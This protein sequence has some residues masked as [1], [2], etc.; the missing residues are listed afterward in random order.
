MTTTLFPRRVIH[1]SKNGEVSIWNVDAAKIEATKKIFNQD[2]RFT[3]I[4][5][6]R[7]KVYFHVFDTFREDKLSNYILTI[8]IYSVD[9]FS[10]VPF[11]NNN[12]LLFYRNGDFI[13][14]NNT[15]ALDLSSNTFIKDLDLTNLMEMSPHRFN[16]SKQSD[17]DDQDQEDE[18]L[19]RASNEI[20]KSILKI[21]ENLYL[22]IKHIVVNHQAKSTLDLLHIVN[23]D[24]RKKVS[25][26]KID[27]YPFTEFGLHIDP[28]IKISPNEFLLV[29]KLLGRSFL[30]TISTN[31]SPSNYSTTNSPFLD[32]LSV[33]IKQVS[34][35]F[36]KT[37]RQGKLENKEFFSKTSCI[38]LAPST[39]NDIKQAE[40]I[41][42]TCTFLP[43][44]LVKLIANLLF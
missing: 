15:C 35:N 16:D 4:C 20:R 29:S 40:E 39:K 11:Y 30:L 17:Q 36:G 22:V 34:I 42:E 5:S 21:S 8:D 6:T 7:G 1:F 14:I 18:I 24:N 12:H 9:I 13:F 28:P 31:Q 2:Y 41:I 19:P 37:G 33:D 25:F 27:I 23:V 32:K 44:V 38:F 26:K 43:I 3:K 10:I